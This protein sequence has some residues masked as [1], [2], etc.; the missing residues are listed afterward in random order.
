M[1]WRMGQGEGHMMLWWRWWEEQPWG[2]PERIAYFQR[3]HP[4]KRWLAFVIRAIWPDLQDDE[5]IH[6]PDAGFER[7]AQLG[8]GTPTEYERDLSDPKWLKR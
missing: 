7:T 3:W 6:P 2:E 8:W 5:G 4:P 1:G